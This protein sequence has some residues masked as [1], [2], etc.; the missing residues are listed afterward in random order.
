VG[1]I[2]LTEAGTL[3]SQDFQATHLTLDSLCRFCLPKITDIDRYLVKLFQKYNS[4]LVFNN[5]V[6]DW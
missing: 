6:E 4:D 1:A 5:I 2:K 3:F